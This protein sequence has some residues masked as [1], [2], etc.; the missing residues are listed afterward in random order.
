MNLD[1][2]PIRQR[3]VNDLIAYVGVSPNGLTKDDLALVIPCSN[4][5]TVISDARRVLRGHSINNDIHFT[6][7][8]DPPASG[9]GQGGSQWRYRLINSKDTYDAAVT[10]YPINRL[11]DLLTRARSQRDDALATLRATTPSTI[12]HK[13]QQI[14]YLNHR[15]CVEDLELLST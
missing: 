2:T 9:G 5:C 7:V 11:G 10:R 3:R 8:C 6:L 14:I 12:E 15:R 13:A 1:M 4:I